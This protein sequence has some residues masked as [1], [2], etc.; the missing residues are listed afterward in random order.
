M[1]Y[2]EYGKTGK[3]VSAVGF[4]GLRFNLDKSNEENAKLVMYAYEKGINYFDTAPGYCNER[5]EE[6]LGIAFRH[7]IKDGKND[8]YVSTKGRPTVCDTVEKT[9]SSVKKSI[10]TLGVDKIDFYHVWCIRKVDHY[11]IA[12]KPGGQYEGL[13]KCKEEGLID[14]IVFSSHQPGDEV[15]KVLDDNKFEGVTM[16]I[17]L[18]NFPYRWNGVEHA[19]NN[20][21]GVV[22]MNPLNGGSIPNHKNSL[23]FLAKENENAVDAALRFNI[24]SPQ[25]T[26]SLIGFGS[27]SDIDHACYIADENN[28]YSNEDIENIKNKL[29]EHMNSTCNGCGYCRVCPQNIN[30]PAYMLLYNEKQM[31]KKSDEQMIDEIYGLECWNYTMNSE[32]RA[33]DCIECGKCEYE[34]TQHLPIIDRLKEIAMWEKIGVNNINV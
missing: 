15:I 3:K 34:C 19:Y 30:T 32:G 11:D 26:I 33:C 6:I 8:F 4:G 31:F 24:G 10:E 12:M 23:S 2:V 21:Y 28:I 27:F 9:V 18:L 17:N 16:G 22:A 25:I 5:S 1:K 20:N 7:L 13:L 29:G 14:H